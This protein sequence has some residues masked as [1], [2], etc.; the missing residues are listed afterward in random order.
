MDGYKLVV[1]FFWTEKSFP[2]AFYF[3]FL[4]GSPHSDSLEESPS[5]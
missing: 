5:L 3:R 4:G 2:P 1:G